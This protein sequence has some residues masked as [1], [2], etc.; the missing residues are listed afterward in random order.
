MPLRRAPRFAPCFLALFIALTLCR[1]GVAA[2][3]TQTDRHDPAVA[4]LEEAA[5]R[6]ANIETLS[7]G[8]RQEK[9]LGILTQP[10]ASQ[11]YMCMTR[12]AD[13]QGGRLL[14]AYTSPAPSGF[15]YENG[16]GVLWE[17]NPANKRQAGAREAK[18]L[19]AIVRHILA[20]IRIDS[21]EIQRAYRLERPEADMPI[22]LLYPRQQSFFTKLEA[23][24]TPPL[25]SMRQLT[26]F[27]ANGDTVRIL[28][29][30]TQI[31]QALPERCAR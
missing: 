15:L 24:F 16:Q 28:F 26:F 6:S 11:G 30:D 1:P 13:A 27:E 8:F 9:K 5:R 10:L 12:D 14:W 20:W 23:V 18:V 3:A 4:L 21:Q 2:Q 19:T 25:D 7:A 29:T 31:N 17:D 22:L